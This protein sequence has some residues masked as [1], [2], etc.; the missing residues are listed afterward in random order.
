MRSGPRRTDLG[1]C[2][3]DHDI[4]RDRKQRAR[5]AFERQPHLQPEGNRGADAEDV[6]DIV[7]RRP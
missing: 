2:V 7:V 6:A 4:K 5:H 1:R 3:S